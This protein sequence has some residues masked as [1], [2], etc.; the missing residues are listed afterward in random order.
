MAHLFK[1]ALSQIESVDAVAFTD[2]L[3]A[4]EHFRL[5]H[6]DYAAVISDYRMPGMDG[7]DLLNKIKQINPTVTRIMI[8]AFDLGDNIFKDCEC[9]DKFL[10]KPVKI[11]DLI[12]E[13][14]NSIFSKTGS[15]KLLLNRN[16]IDV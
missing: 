11:V 5:N 10:R 6:K 7:E 16:D 9:I 3:I 2:P 13:V 4:L 15:T 12:Q 1:D 8:S 14:Q